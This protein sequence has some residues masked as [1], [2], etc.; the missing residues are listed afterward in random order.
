[1]ASIKTRDLFAGAIIFL[2]LVLCFYYH[3]KGRTGQW[4]ST[5]VSLWQKEDWGKLQALGDNLYRVGKE[6]TEAY[7]LAMLASEQAQNAAKT[8][9]FAE[10][11]ANTRVL[12]WKMETQLDRIYQPDSLRKRITLFRTRIIYSVLFLLALLLAVSV[13]RKNPYRMAPAILSVFGMIVLLL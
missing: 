7:F 12:N 4:H 5:T 1:M 10:R 2:F 8:K 9:L 6:D 3:Q 13:A 11:L